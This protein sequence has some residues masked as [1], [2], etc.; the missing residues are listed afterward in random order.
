MVTAELLGRFTRLTEGEA[1]RPRRWCRSHLGRVARSRHRGGPTPGR[2]SG[3]ARHGCWRRDGGG[4]RPRRRGGVGTALTGACSRS[5]RAP[6]R[7]QP[8]AV[9]RVREPRDDLGGDGQADAR[10]DREVPGRH[11]G[12]TVTSPWPRPSRPTAPR[13]SPSPPRSSTGRSRRQSWSSPGPT[14]VRC[15]GRSSRWPW[16]TTCASSSPTTCRPPPTCTAT[17]SA[18]PTPWT[19]WPVSPRIHRARA[20]L[21]LRLRGREAGGRH[22]PRPPPRRRGRAERLFGELLIGDVPLPLGRTIGGI[23]VPTDLK[24]AQQLP[25][26]LND[27]GAGRALHGAHAP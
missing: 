21:H 20:E 10:L 24:V 2:T 7:P 22:V 25:M 6:R 14:T 19:A 8:A 13:I 1:L 26:V 27:A 15:R 4:R 3:E 17:A 12:G 9:G 5:T 11:R 16:V 23:T 18:C